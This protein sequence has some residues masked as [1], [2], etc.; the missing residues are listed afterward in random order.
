MKHA[1]RFLAAAALVLA[2][3]GGLILTVAGFRAAPW[4]GD[5]VLVLLLLLL[6][7][8]GA[9]VWIY[10]QAIRGLKYA[11]PVEVNHQGRWAE[12][13]ALLHYDHW[14]PRALNIWGISIGHHIWLRYGPPVPTR[15]GR[16]VTQR[17][18]MAHELA[19]FARWMLKPDLALFLAF[20]WQHTRKKKNRPEE[21][22][23]Y[24]HQHSIAVGTSGLVRFPGNWLELEFS[25]NY[26]D[27]DE[28]RED[29]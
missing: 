28:I 20:L 10:L 7:L 15:H 9:G 6:A 22:F 4:W 16:P 1:L 17:W 26:G 3:G 27:P 21:K 25:D 5:L 2:V 18:Q 24:E 8:V 12:H 13:T 19:H 14:L 23:A 29:R 11:K